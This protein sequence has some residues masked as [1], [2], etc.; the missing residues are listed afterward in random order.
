MAKIRHPS[1][2]NRERTRVAFRD[3]KPNDEDLA[4]LF[5]ITR[6]W[7]GELRKRGVLPAGEPLPELVARM[8]SHQREVEA[9]KAKG[10]RPRHD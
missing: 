4:W 2:L 10:R 8:M 1:A 6:K 3:L 5:G 7:V 9:G